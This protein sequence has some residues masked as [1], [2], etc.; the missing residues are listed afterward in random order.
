MVVMILFLGI[1]ID[2]GRTYLIHLKM[3]NAVD[4]ASIA[5]AEDMPQVYTTSA[6]N[7][8]K[9]KVIDIIQRNGIKLS[10]KELICEI[11]KDKGDIFAAR[12]ILTGTVK[13]YF[14]SLYVNQDSKIR[15]GNLVYIS[16][17]AAADEGY[18]IKILDA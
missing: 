18:E 2:L 1:T 7:A 4:L 12:I 17:S 6:E 15:V 10:D 3:R 9:A 13:H 16:T 8:M 14:A 5:I 11:I